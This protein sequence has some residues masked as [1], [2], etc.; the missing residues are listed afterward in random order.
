[1]KTDSDP[2]QFKLGCLM[3]S[4]GWDHWN[5]ELNFLLASLVVPKVKLVSRDCFCAEQFCK[6]CFC[7]SSFC[8][9]STIRRINHNHSQLLEASQPLRQGI[10]FLLATDIIQDPKEILNVFS[11]F[12][13][14]C[15]DSQIN[16]TFNLWSGLCPL[17]CIM[18]PYFLDKC[19]FIFCNQDFFFLP[20]IRSFICHH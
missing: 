19:S 5:S 4:A 1:M 13:K 8:Q 15:S 2:R 20:Q 3:C 17:V 9:P 18:S 11:F 10:L 7:S 12:P 16:L 14:Y 6:S